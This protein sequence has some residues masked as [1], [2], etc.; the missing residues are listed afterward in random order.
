MTQTPTAS[1][2]LPLLS[3]KIDFQMAR[4]SERKENRGRDQLM[5]ER[6]QVPQ[7][8]PERKPRDLSIGDLI[9]QV[10]KK[11]GLEGAFWLDEIKERWEEITGAQVA[12]N[13]RPGQYD[14]GLLTIYV[15][16]SGWLM[17]MERYAKGMVLNN[18]QDVFGKDKVR[19]IEFR[20]DP[21][22]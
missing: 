5:R 17:E 3:V 18:I 12:R 13:T 15:S 7:Y 8:R 2:T 6:L 11:C 21:G 22:D 19:A 4:R 9:P 16:H 14:N 1:L 10:V 20:I